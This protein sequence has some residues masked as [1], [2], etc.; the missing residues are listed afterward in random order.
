M[1]WNGL[2]GLG[3]R[4]EGNGTILKGTEWYGMIWDRG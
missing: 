3:M 2:D 1:W 4:W